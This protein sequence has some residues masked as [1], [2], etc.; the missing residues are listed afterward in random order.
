[1][2]VFIWESIQKYFRSGQTFKIAILAFYDY[3]FQQ[4]LKHYFIIC[5]SK[6][7]TER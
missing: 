1:M 6:V 3:I 7:Y 5:L 2:E 4:Y